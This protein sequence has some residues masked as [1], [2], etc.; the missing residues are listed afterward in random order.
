MFAVGMIV[1][2]IVFLV[3][4]AIFPALRFFAKKQIV[5]SDNVDKV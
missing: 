5:G 3:L 2:A 1:G 4:Q